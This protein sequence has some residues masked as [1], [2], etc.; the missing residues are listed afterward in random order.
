[1]GIIRHF[2][3]VIKGSFGCSKPQFTHPGNS[4]DRG[5]LELNTAKEMVFL[6]IL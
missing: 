3:A 2:C 4:K 5:L 1:M 6:S